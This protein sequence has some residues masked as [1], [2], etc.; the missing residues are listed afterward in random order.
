VEYSLASHDWSN[1]EHD[2]DLIYVKV[3]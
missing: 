3:D 1:W 2:F